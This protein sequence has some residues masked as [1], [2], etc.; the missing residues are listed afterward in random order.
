LKNGVTAHPLIREEHA[1]GGVMRAI[2]QAELRRRMARE[3]RGSVALEAAA[4]RL[5][6]L[7]RSDDPET[8]MWAD[9]VLK[10]SIGERPKT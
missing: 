9:D 1:R 8:A 3:S 6:G 2:V 7:L 4:K 10:R 5:G